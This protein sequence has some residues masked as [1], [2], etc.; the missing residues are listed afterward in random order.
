M[1]NYKTGFTYH[2]INYC[3]FATHYYNGTSK[4]FYPSNIL[5]NEKNR[6]II[7]YDIKGNYITHYKENIIGK[8]HFKIC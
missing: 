5:L 3:N 7:A 6:I 4:L 8:T 2:K 1:I